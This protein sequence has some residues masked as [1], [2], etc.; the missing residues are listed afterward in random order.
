MKSSLV[1]ENE[2]NQETRLEADERSNKK[3]EQVPFFDFRHFTTPIKKTCQNQLQEVEVE[4]E[5]VQE[6]GDHPAE[7]EQQ[8]FNLLQEGFLQV[9]LSL[10]LSP[11]CDLSS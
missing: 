11:V 1:T 7:V 5:E 4:V 9:S 6:V 2:T 8:E 3:L 10:S